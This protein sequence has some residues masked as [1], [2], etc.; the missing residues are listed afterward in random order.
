MIELLGAEKNCYGKTGAGDEIILLNDFKVFMK[1]R[2]IV[3]RLYNKNAKINVFL[4]STISY[5]SYI[6]Q[7]VKAFLCDA[8]ISKNGAQSEIKIINTFNGFRL[9]NFW[10]NKWTRYSLF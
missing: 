2:P 3:H 8:Q 10:Y 6:F 5:I 9:E 1:K 4:C 7:Y